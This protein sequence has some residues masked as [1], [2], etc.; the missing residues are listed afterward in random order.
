MKHSTKLILVL[1]TLVCVG[2]LSAQITD[3]AATGFSNDVVR[4]VAEALRNTYASCKATVAHWNATGMSS[5]ITNTADEIEDGAATDG[6]NVIT[7]SDATSII[8]RCME[9]ITDY[10]AAGNAKLNTVEKP[11]VRPTIIGVTVP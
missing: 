8:T 4:R 9:L 10:E 6:R 11:S 2:P 5:K 3:P 1:L 7:G